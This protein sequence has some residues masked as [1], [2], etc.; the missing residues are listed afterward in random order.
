MR[1]RAMLEKSRI[2]IISGALFLAVLSGCSGGGGTPI[3]GPPGTP[4]PTPTSTPTPT[5]TPTPTPS[6]TPVPVVEVVPTEAIWALSSQH[7]LRATG[8][9][10]S[11]G[12]NWVVVESGCGGMQTANGTFDSVSNLTFNVYIA[13][14]IAPSTP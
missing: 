2:R 9:T 3:D 14:S 13:P 5:A 11:G 7:S 6:P 1:L 4:T 8:G 12:L 10:A